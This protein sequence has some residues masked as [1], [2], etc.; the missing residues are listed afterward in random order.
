MKIIVGI[1]IEMYL[2]NDSRWKFLKYL[3][4]VNR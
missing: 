2:D 4:K 1:L 3:D